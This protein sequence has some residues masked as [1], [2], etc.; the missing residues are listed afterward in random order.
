[1]CSCF[2]YMV[3][4]GHGVGG[5]YYLRDEGAFFALCLGGAFRFNTRMMKASV[6]V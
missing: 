4:G 1:M 2:S 6:T 5:N 3:G